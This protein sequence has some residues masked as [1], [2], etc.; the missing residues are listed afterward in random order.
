MKSKHIFLFILLVAILGSC[1][2]NVWEQENDAVYKSIKKEY[3]LN[4]DGSVDYRYQHQL[5]YITHNSFNRMFGESFVIYDPRF[6]QLKI[7]KSETK[8][9]DGKLVASPANAFNEVLPRFAAGA[10]AYNHLREMVVTHAGLE[11]GC[12]VNFD[13]ELHSN[14]GY[15]PY[16]NDNII[17]QQST[18][19]ENMEIV[20]KVP[21][22]I[23]LNY[24]LINSKVKPVISKK[25]G[26]TSYT[27]KFENLDMVANES[28]Q[29][30]EDLFIPKL[31][32]S[33]VS[34]NE[35]IADVISNAD[36]TLTD[37]MKS[38]VQKR[39]VGKKQGLEYI[40][41][42][43]KI[44]GSE[45]N[46]FYVPIEYTAYSIR[47][48][49]DVWASNGATQ[50][51]K[52]VLLNEFAKFM[53]F[54]SKLIFAI[55]EK[56]FDHSI[57]N[58]KDFGKILMQTKFEDQEYIFQ[59]NQS[60]KNT[61]GFEMTNDKLID[62]AGNEVILPTYIKE[63]KN[64]VSATGTIEISENGD[65]Q[66]SLLIKLTGIRY[67]YF[68][69]LLN[70]ENAKTIVESIVPAGSIGKVELLTFD[71]SGCEVKAEIKGKEIWK[72]QGDY[73]FIKIF[74][75]SLGID[76]AHLRPLTG[77]RET[78]ISIGY[79]V[80]ENYDITYML[81]AGFALVGNEVKY[82]IANTTGEIKINI[83][84]V[85]NKVQV[86]RLLKIEQSVIISENYAG[87]KTLIDGWNKEKV[88]T[89]II[90]KVQTE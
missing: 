13:Y 54:E 51:E 6:Q 69:L 72:N 15:F 37:E 39:M 48:L 10:P 22:G 90:K 20:V 57:G 75:S 33:T 79:P 35:A 84:S 8:M 47:P 12:V 70:P 63:T 3:Q 56:T 81:P 53:G 60:Q 18:P 49:K 86:N 23:S 45:I 40:K 43:Q 82:E 21:E 2:P 80:F 32:F 26:L 16:L 31:V 68:E 78:P 34:L 27:W 50:F 87:F 4:V 65:Y 1:Q 62:V 46:G 76:A 52:M 19:I 44:V 89:L 24:K 42:L 30:N 59:Y 5:K 71:R 64:M 73:F 36:L 25:E 83:N 85:E 77:N 38:F 61:L 17:I 74:S 88:K 28:N 67:P 41:E 58:L 14:S 11:L 29:P 55:P 66:G 9:A 7:N